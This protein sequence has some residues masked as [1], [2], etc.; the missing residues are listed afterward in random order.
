MVSTIEKDVAHVEATTRINLATIHNH[1]VL[2]SP[3]AGFRA[4]YRINKQ[5]LGAF[6]PAEKKNRWINQ[7]S[8][9]M[10]ENKQRLEP[11]TRQPYSSVDGGTNLHAHLNY[12]H[13][14][15]FESQ[16]S[17]Q[18]I[19]RTEYWRGWSAGTLGIMFSLGWWIGIPKPDKTKHREIPGP[20]SRWSYSH[21]FTTFAPTTVTA[22]MCNKSENTHKPS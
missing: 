7:L 22:T 16:S 2:S 10:G 5:L 11:P 4:K 19:W 12:F 13:P 14:V 17:A 21:Q 9:N 20:Y 8:L 1:R 6:N 15:D 3:T 18:E